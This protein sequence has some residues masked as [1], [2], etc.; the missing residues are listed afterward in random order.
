[1]QPSAGAG[2]SEDKKKAI[3][4][5]KKYLHI[6]QLSIAGFEVFVTA[7]IFFF[8]YDYI[9]L[10]AAK[11]SSCNFLLFLL[12]FSVCHCWTRF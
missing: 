8:F 3:K 2:E 9:L 6:R 10:Y 7:L 12:T 4:R 1:M 5:L 11:I